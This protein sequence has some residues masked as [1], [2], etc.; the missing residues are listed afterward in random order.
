MI[1]A[2]VFVVVAYGAD[3][4]KALDA[5]LEKH[6]VAVAKADL[7]RSNAFEKSRDESVSLL[8]KLANDSYTKK[9]RLVETAAW[10]EVLRLDRNHVRAKRYFSDLGTLEA[11]LVEFPADDGSGML[12]PKAGKWRTRYSDG[13]AAEFALAGNGGVKISF[14]K[15]PAGDCRADFKNG[16]AIVVAPHNNSLE[17]WTIGGDRLFIE[18]W[19]GLKTLDAE[20]PPALLGIATR[21]E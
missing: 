8:V 16:V 6:R 11:V 18:H 9:D 19:Y 14:G 15:K 13:A 21:I 12:F 5:I 20:K 2:T 3:V 7:A 4:P 1:L 17:R 10:K